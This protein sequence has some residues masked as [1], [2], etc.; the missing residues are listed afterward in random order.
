MYTSKI[1]SSDRDLLSVVFY[2]TQTNKNSADFKH[3]Y[4]LQDLDNPGKG[5]R[6]IGTFM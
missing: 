2:G 4:V 5:N 6:E 3:V 1:I